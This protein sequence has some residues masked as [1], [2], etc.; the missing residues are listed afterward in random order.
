MPP[1]QLEQLIHD[2][3][4]AYLAANG[5]AIQLV[6]ERGWFHIRYNKHHSRGTLFR[7]K[8]ILIMTE[9]L[10]QRAAQKESAP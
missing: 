7:K 2:Y 10:R 9:T 3:E 5:S 4:A 6:Y 8:Q 1:P